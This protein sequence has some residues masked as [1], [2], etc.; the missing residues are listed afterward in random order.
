VLVDGKSRADARVTEDGSAAE[1]RVD[2]LSEAR[3][4]E[5]LV[6]DGGDDDA[7]DR[8]AWADGVLLCGEP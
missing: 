7:G 1:L 5:L 4:L 8:A 2:G 3:R 6:T